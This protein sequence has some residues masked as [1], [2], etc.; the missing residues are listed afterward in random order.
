MSSLLADAA[1]ASRSQYHMLHDTRLAPHFEFIG[2]KSTHYGI[3]E[4][5]GKALPFGS[6]ATAKGGAAAASCC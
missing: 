4:G 6:A 3:F 2:D 1:A 5:C